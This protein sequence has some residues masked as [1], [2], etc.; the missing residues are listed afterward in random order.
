MSLSQG[1]AR[2]RHQTSLTNQ[3]LRLRASSLDSEITALR[4]QL[5]RLLA[6]RGVIQERLD[7]IV[8]PVLTLPVE[9]TSQIFCWTV[10]HPRPHSWI[11]F[12]KY[13]VLGQICRL[14]REVAL[15]TPEM[16]NKLDLTPADAVGT[17]PPFR[18]QTLLSRAA[19]LPLSISFVA[20]S[21]ADTHMLDVLAAHSR[22][23]G[24]IMFVGPFERLAPFYTMTH[25]LPLLKSLKLILDDTPNDDVFGTMFQNAPLLRTVHLSC[26]GSQQP[27]LP[28]AQLTSLHIRHSTSDDLA[29]IL[30]WT[31]NLVH[32]IIHDVYMELD[33][34]PFL[35]LAHLRSLVLVHPAPAEQHAIMSLIIAAPLQTLRIG[36]WH[37]LCRPFPHSGSLE[38]LWVDIFGAGYY[39]GE[40]D[41]LIDPRSLDAFAGMTSL[42]N[43]TLVLYAYYPTP[44]DVSVDPL[45]RRLA[46][47]LDFLPALESLSITLL[48]DP[49]DEEPSTFDMVALS[50]MLR[51]RARDSDTSSQLRNFELRSRRTLPELSPAAVGLTVQGMRIHLE[52][53]PRLD[54]PR[55]DFE[56]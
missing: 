7:A 23:W 55:A 44:E 53:S 5:D 12:H 19:T 48:E 52:S 11:P 39:A 34:R 18:L 32:L 16:W 30:G 13:F 40:D 37:C 41:V 1:P 3:E 28:W 24:K 50:T 10:L 27:A 47:D 26:F 45:I 42:R 8:Y 51:A 2:T 4:A 56:L 46:A 21:T 6:D 22:M 33:T 31:L 54:S 29:N 9:I 15:S 43:L 17:Q 20:S 49:S 14:R 25:E 35:P 38:E 36:A